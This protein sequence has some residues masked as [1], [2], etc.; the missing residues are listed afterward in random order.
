MTEMEHLRNRLLILEGR[1]RS[2][3]VVCAV[4]ILLGITAAVLPRA[5][6]L[7]ARG[8]VIVDSTGRERI[9]IGAPIRDASTDPKL[10][11]T[12]GMVV[13]D[14][15]GH[16]HVSLG[17]NN[18]LVFADGRTGT[19]IATDAGMTIYDPRNGGERGGIGVFA[20]GRANVCLDWGRKGKEAACMSV[21][22]GDQ[23]A[24]VLLNGTPDQP[25][26]DRVGLFAGADGIGIVKAFG[27][28]TNNGG[29]RLEAGKGTPVIA[30]YDTTGRR[31]GNALDK[32]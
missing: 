16:L 10:A 19:R 21:A 31:A 24:A 5:D 2:V 3:S 1:L 15:A 9:V 23:Y 22:P 26:F 18:P 13:L 17:A 14:S 6:V 4:L 7:R 20:D 29:I 12:V 11:Q 25:Q 27:G 30:L 32:Q 8:L 28:G